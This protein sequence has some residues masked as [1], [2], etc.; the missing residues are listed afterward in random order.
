MTH[1]GEK[2]YKCKFCDFSARRKKIL[3]EHV[4]KMHG[5]EAKDYYNDDKKSLVD[6]VQNEEFIDCDTSNCDKLVNLV[7]EEEEF[8]YQNIP[9]LSIRAKV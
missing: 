5:V 8:G 7:K 6:L 9:M 3:M 2:P 1:T 4:E